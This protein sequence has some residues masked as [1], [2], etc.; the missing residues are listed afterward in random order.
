L[1][2]G[3]ALV[4]GEMKR[5]LTTIFVSAFIAFAAWVPLWIVERND[6]HAMPVGLGLLT[7]AV[8][9]VSGAVAFVALIKL[10]IFAARSAK[11]P[12]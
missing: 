5:Y 6:P 12:S 2:N 7:F 9:F 3:N 8:S 1:G 4:N 10:L 11:K